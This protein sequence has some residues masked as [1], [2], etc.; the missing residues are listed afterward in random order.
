MSAYFCFRSGHI[1]LQNVTI[2]AIPRRK[3]IL[4]PVLE[5][6]VFVPNEATLN[7]RDSIRVILQI[8]LEN[9]HT[10]KIKIVEIVDK[11][12]DDVPLTQ[13][14][15]DI[16]PDLPLIQPD[17]RIFSSF[18]ANFDNTVVENKKLSDVSNIHTAIGQNL[19]SRKAVS[20]TK[21]K[22]T[23]FDNNTNF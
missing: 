16:L 10:V 3:Y 23:F 4:E 11:K 1:C 7:Y 2:T 5:K 13:L 6:Y 22:T 18:S 9:I 19:L 17:I 15:Y 20:I 14:M 8:V 21:H 12:M